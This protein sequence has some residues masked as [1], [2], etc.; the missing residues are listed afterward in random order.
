[1][2]QNTII[3]ENMFHDFQMKYYKTA[4]M[5]G[6]TKELDIIRINH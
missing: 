5:M 3:S 4:S 1:M 6:Q 2:P